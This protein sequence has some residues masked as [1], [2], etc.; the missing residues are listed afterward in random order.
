[1]SR[2]ALVPFTIAHGVE[3]SFQGGGVRVQGSK[4]ELFLTLPPGFEVKVENGHGRVLQISPS[5]GG[6]ALHGTLCRIMQNMIR[7]VSVGFEKRLELVGVGYKAELQGGGVL[8]LSLGYSHDIL[9]KIPDGITIGLEKP[10]LFKI[11]GIDK[12]KVGQVAA[13][14][15]RFRPPEPYKGKGVRIPGQFLR[16]KEGKTKK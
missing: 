13:E 14:I 8:K 3:I 9:Y 11:L 5:E 1:M 2:I 10:T 7:G 4:G 15:I 12:Q 16:M 6:S